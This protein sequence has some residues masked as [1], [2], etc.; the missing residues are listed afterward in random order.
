M[1]LLAVGSVAFDS[2]RTPRGKAE[3]VL[4]GSA[5]YFALAASYFSPVR[6]VG[7][8]G[9]DFAPEHEAVFTRRGICVR[10]IERATGKSFFWEGEYEANPNQRRTLT[11]ELNVFETFAPKLPPD[12]LDSKYLFLGNIDPA[13]QVTVRNQLG[14]ARF[15][16]GDTMNYW[17]NSKQKE[18]RAFLSRLDLLMIND[19]EA[20]Q[21]TGEYNLHR[22]ARGVIDLGPRALVIKRGEHGASLYTAAKSRSN[23]S[24]AY[25]AVPAYPLEEVWDPTGAGDSFAG[26]VMGY[27]AEQERFDEAALRRAVVYGSV[28]GSFACERFGVDRLCHLTREEIDQRFGSFEEFTTFS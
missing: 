5:A 27:L 11:T 15:T 10:G 6:V 19:S 16:A 20:T 18:L 24:L 1:T 22:A 7:V 21:L 17:I 4:G 28:M 3:R 25:F 8:V 26:G 23:G 12:Y 2:I 14:A 13:L 9:D